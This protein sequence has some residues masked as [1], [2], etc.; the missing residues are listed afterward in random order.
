LKAVTRF[1]ATL[2]PVG[3]APIAPA[4]AGSAVVTAIGWFLPV[5]RLPV[6]LAL[7]ALGTAL[8]IWICGEAEKQLGH[9]AKPIVA[10]EVVGQSLALLW[11]PHAWP[12]FVTAFLLFRVFDVWKPLGAREAQRLPGGFGVVADDFIA[13]ITSC[14]VFH[15]LTL[16]ATRVLHH[17][18]WQAF[19]RVT[20]T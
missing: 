12:A 3:S 17:S 9:D 19:E 18:P 2:G 14:A 15:G 8:A 1:L 4:T 6:T 20:L 7:L 13:G 5:P 11:V 16:L 10:D